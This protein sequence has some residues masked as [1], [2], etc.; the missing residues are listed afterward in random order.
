L[1]S[2][3]PADG[4]MMTGPGTREN[5]PRASGDLREDLADLVAYQFR[6]ADETCVACDNY[7]ALWGYERL[8]GIKGNSFETDRDLLEPLLRGNLPPEGRILIAGA[9]DAGLL[10]LT[11]QVMQGAAARITV[12]DRCATPL[13]VCRRYGESHVL[14]VAT[15]HTDLAAAPLNSRYDLAFAHNVLMLQPMAQHIGFLSN[16]RR[17]LE[18]NGAFVLVNRVRAS[19]PKPI[20]P[21][22]YATRILEAL[23]ARGIALP[24]AESGFRERLETYAEKQHAW[25][26]AIIDL[27][28]VEASLREAGFRIAE[29]IEH[30]RRRTV[31][32]RDGGEPTPMPTHIFVAIPR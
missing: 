19:K 3:I 18:D 20:P 29:R 16:I 28:H 2:N 31:P 11:A 32:D 8:A 25:S 27:E 5:Q 4:D 30:H 17:S 22:H 6:T 7:H 15:A 14:K 10:A 9:A 12:A 1:L 13:A 24:E 26:D 23:S 21:T